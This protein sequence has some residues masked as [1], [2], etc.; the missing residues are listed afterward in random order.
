MVS[1]RNVAGS[2]KNSMK[3]KTRY[4]ECYI[5]VEQQSILLYRKRFLS[6][7]TRCLYNNL[8]MLTTQ[9]VALDGSRGTY[10]PGTNSIMHLYSTVG[11]SYGAIFARMAP[12]AMR[13]QWTRLLTSY[14]VSDRWWNSSR[15]KREPMFR[16][17]GFVTNA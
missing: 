3:S 13:E 12:S 7:H 2:S 6:E 1:E 17:F 5:P 16:C 4:K 11:T 10:K 8:Y 14:R 9:D 15:H